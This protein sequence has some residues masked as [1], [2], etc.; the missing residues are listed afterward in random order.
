MQWLNICL[1]SPSFAPFLS[2]PNNTAGVKKNAQEFA[3]SRTR[4]F[5][6]DINIPLLKRFIWIKWVAPSKQNKETRMQAPV[7]HAP[8]SMYRPH[9]PLSFVVGPGRTSVCSEPRHFK[10]PGA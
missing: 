3:C 8:V 6:N 7:S 2:R 4:S 10:P 1:I 9:R 5:G